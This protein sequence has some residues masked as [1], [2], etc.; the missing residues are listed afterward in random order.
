MNITK[1]MKRKCIF[2]ITMGTKIEPLLD[3]ENLKWLNRYDK[4]YGIL[5]LFASPNIL[6]HIISI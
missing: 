1:F 5:R 4:A 3:D 6:D 2:G